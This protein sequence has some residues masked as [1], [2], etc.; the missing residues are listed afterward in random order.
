MMRKTKSAEIRTSLMIFCLMALTGCADSK[1]VSW[2][3]GEPGDS[4][5][6][7]PQAVGAPPSQNETGW[8]NLASVPPKPKD[9]STPAFRRTTIRQMN[10]A[11][12]EAEAI[13]Q[14]VGTPTE[15]VK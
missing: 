7:V 3:T 8:P 11:K 9:F 2:L 5:L 1:W 4:V 6:N 10:A 13:R 12:T 15:T 14:R